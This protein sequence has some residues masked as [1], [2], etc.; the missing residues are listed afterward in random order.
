MPILSLNIPAGAVA[1]LSTAYGDLAGQALQD[2]VKADLISY[3]KLRVRK[4][5][6]DQAASTAR[7]AVTDITIT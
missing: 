3:L 7:A 6:E 2:A 4:T 5:L 1:S